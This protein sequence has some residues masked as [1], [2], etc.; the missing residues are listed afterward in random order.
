MN[1]LTLAQPSLFSEASELAEAMLFRPPGGEPTLD[2]VLVRVWE[3]LAA[4][5]AVACPLCGG[6]MI[7]DGMQRGRGG[8]CMSCESTLS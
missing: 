1:T 2:E 3:G 4:Q 7:P 5:H 8:R 6:E